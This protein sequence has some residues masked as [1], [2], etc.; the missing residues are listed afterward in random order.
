MIFSSKKHISF[1]FEVLPLYYRSEERS[2][3]GSYDELM[4][5]S[6]SQTTDEALQARWILWEKG[7]S[8]GVGFDLFIF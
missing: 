5:Q 1:L 3:C 8:V 7:A 4:S 6:H 2:C